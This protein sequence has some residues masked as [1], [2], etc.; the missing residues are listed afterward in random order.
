M[1]HGTSTLSLLSIFPK[2]IVCYDLRTSDKGVTSCAIAHEVDFHFLKNTVQDYVFDKLQLG[3][4]QKM[5]PFYETI[6]RILPT[7]IVDEISS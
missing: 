3:S 1:I 2:W 7:L 5:N 6:E 4:A